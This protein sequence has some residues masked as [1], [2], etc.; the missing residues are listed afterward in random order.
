MNEIGVDFHESTCSR[1]RHSSAPSPELLEG[2]LYPTG[3]PARGRGTRQ[4]K[5]RELFCVT[6]T[7]QVTKTTSCGTG[8]HTVLRLYT[9][10][11]VFAK[12]NHFYDTVHLSISKYQIRI[13]LIS[14][15]KRMIQKV[16]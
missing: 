11:R 10:T 3:R 2:V 9:N 15:E 14:L 8:G 7:V 5:L 12:I 6:C 13:I 1:A 4:V 16:K